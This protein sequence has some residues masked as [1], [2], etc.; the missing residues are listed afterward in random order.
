MGDIEGLTFR[1]STLI[2]TNFS[3]LGGPTTVYAID[4]TAA[5]ATPITS[6]SQGPVRAMALLNPNTVEVASD[7]PVSQSLVSVNLLNGTNTL[8]AAAST[9]AALIAAMDFGIDGNLYALDPLG[10]EFIIASNGAGIPV[11]NTGG[12]YWLDLAVAPPATLTACPS[13]AAWHCF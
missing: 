1:G 9:G 8:G 7:S 3:D 11:G 6:F 5:A 10:N 2:G 12:Q 4:T 13:L